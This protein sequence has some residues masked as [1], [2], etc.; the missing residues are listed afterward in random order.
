MPAGADR[1]A[2]LHELAHREV[3]GSPTCPARTF[4]GAGLKREVPQ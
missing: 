2:L 4:A 1:K 3:C